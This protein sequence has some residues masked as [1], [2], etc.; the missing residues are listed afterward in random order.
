MTSSQFSFH[1]SF[2]SY[3]QVKQMVRNASECLKIGGIFCGTLPDSNEIIKRLK[4]CGGN[5][6][7][8]EVYSIRFD[9]TYEEMI[10]D[11]IPLFGA[12]YDF[13]LDEVVNCP[14]FLVYF[15]AFEEIC[16]SFGLKLIF[17]KRFDRFFDEN[18]DVECN[19]NLLNYMDALEK[20]PPKNN[21]R[22][23]GKPT[24]Y[25]HVNDFVMNRASGQSISSLGTLSKS[26][27]EAV[28]LY[29]VFSFR[30]ISDDPI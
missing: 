2:E 17:K 12:K 16:H 20:Y 11:G 15:P 22:M 26:E 30:K 10:R 4:E 19:N 18:K 3:E 23:V 29:L 8:N 7:G 27:W 28:T 21:E 6:Y 25:R 13:L 14:E 1:Y 9:K 24:D 5:R